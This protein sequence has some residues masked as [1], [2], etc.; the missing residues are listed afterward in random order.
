MVIDFPYPDITPLDIPESSETQIY[1][2]IPYSVNQTGIAHVTYALA[3]PIQSV[4]LSELAQGKRQILI[5]SDD[6]SRPTPVDQFL[7]LILEDLHRANILDHQISFLMALGTHRHMTKGEM[8][9]KL[10]PEVVRQYQV[11]NHNWE[12]PDCLEYVG[13]TDQGVP[14][15]INQLVTQSDLVIGLGS[16]MPIDICGFTGGGKILVPGVSGQITVDEM[17]WNR[18]DV[19][20]DQVL[21]QVK[22][23]IRASIDSLARKAGLD[24]IVNVILNAKDEIVACVA[25]DMEAAHQQGCE[26]AKKVY[27]VP[28]PNE[29]DIV[30]ADSYPF[31]IEFWQ[32]NKALDNAGEVVKKDGVVILVTP[33]YEGFSR[34][35]PEILEIGYHPTQRIKEMVHTGQIKHKVVGVHMC[36]VSSVAVEKARLILVSTGITKEQTEQVGFLW[37]KTPTQALEMALARV[38]HKPQIAVLKNAARMLPKVDKGNTK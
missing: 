36:Q 18:I 21:G 31:D 10:G 15:W 26:I 35:H 9:K 32:A 4:P 24:F 6:V 30:I 16:I 11:Y 34:M 8:E 7:P 22:N 20:S 37:A 28:I 33:C 17:H 19:P 1:N 27:E 38:N 13:D 25:G 5:V 14:V 2:M 23:P 29:Y 3:N 12:N